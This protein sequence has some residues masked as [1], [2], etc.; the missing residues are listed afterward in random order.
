M[1]VFLLLVKMH[2]LFNVLLRRSLRFVSQQRR[3]CIFRCINLCWCTFLIVHFRS[4]L[5]NKIILNKNRTSIQR[6]CSCFTLILHS[7][8]CIY[9]ITLFSISSVTFAIKSESAILPISPSRLSRTETVLFSISLSPTT[10][11]YGTFS[12]CASRIL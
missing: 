5:P 8:L 10:S 6:F 3:V 4:L 2:A 9:L 1:H 12:S 7:A 11:I